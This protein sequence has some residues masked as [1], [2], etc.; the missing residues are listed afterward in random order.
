MKCTMGLQQ[1]VRIQRLLSGHLGGTRG[2]SLWIA[3]LR[4]DILPSVAH[5]VERDYS[6]DDHSPCRPALWLDNM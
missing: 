2:E 5:N 1:T 6:S 4:D 3:C